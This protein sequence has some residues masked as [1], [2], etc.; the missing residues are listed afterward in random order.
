MLVLASG[1]PR[2][3]ELLR[4]IGVSFDVCPADIDE[5]P[6]D[7][8]LPEDYVLRLS[9]EKAKTVL[10]LD[11]ERI[12]LGSDT[13]V[14]LDGRLFGKPSDFFE[15]KMMMSEL[16][17]KEHKVM[18]AVTILNAEQIKSSI[19][20]TSVHFRDL[21]EEEIQYYWHTGEPKDKAGGYAIQGIAACFVE[22]IEGSYSGVMGLPLFETCELLQE[23]GLMSFDQKSA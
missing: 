6:Q 7:G 4:Q 18:S 19:S 11:E 8:E 14:T 15:F 23:F 12:V 21:Q 16:S 3:A 22:R 1:S 5:R 13:I 2:R 20:V 10:G 9:Q 17:G